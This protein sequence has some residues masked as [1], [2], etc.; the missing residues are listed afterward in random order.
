MEGTGVIKNGLFILPIYQKKDKINVIF[1][2]LG[3]RLN[4]S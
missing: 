3:K 2:V 1:I 4:A